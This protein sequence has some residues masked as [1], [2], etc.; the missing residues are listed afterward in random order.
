[1][2]A[3]IF[4]TRARQHVAHAPERLLGSTRGPLWWDRG[5]GQWTPG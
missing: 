2:Y 3:A 1:M 5:H 4:T